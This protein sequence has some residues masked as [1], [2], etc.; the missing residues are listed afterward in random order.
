MKVIRTI[1]VS[2]LLFM[3]ALAGDLAPSFK[4]AAALA[5][6]QERDPL[7][8]AYMQHDLNP[9]YQKK[10]SPV[11]Q[12]CLAENRRPNLSPFSFVAAIQK[13]GRVVRVYVDHETSIFR[14]VRRTLQRD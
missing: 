8:Q 3:M 4:E 7:V 5:D 14:C 1:I 12:A 9:Y 11:F 2:F 6:T 13:N 10:Y